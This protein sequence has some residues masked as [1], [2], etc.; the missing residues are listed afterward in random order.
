MLA[1][2]HTCRRA[3]KNYKKVVAKLGRTK[4]THFWCKNI[5]HIL[6][7]YKVLPY[8][9]HVFAL[10]RYINLHLPLV[11]SVEGPG[12]I[13]ESTSTLETDLQKRNRSCA[14]LR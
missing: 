14:D 2:F 12:L 6:G 11:F 13:S 4:I 7:F 3:T 1:C 8:F 10:G 5:C 9:I